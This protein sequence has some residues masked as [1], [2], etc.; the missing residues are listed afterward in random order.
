MFRLIKLLKTDKVTNIPVIQAEISKAMRNGFA[1]IWGL[2]AIMANNFPRTQFIPHKVPLNRFVKI[3]N[4]LRI[5]CSQFV[6]SSFKPEISY[7]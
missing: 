4:D 2:L 6:L 5:K 7:K 1:K 3:K